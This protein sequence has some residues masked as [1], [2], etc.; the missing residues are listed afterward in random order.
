MKTRM[1]LWTGA[2]VLVLAVV[3]SVAFMNRGHAT[4][5]AMG[6]ADT[7]PPPA[8]SEK[9]IEAA[10]PTA[11]TPDG[12]APYAN[13]HYHFALAYPKNLAVT[14]HTENGG[15]MTITFED[16]AGEQ[17]FQIF[18]LPYSGTQ[19]DAA[20]FKLDEPSGVMDSPTDVLVDGARATM[21]FGRNSIMGD[22]REVWCIHGGF[23]YEVTT[24]KDLDPWLA[25]IMSTWK[26]AK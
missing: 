9:V 3:A 22:T 7:V 15:A 12:F 8:V 1:W 2:A 24:Y 25:Q 5:V 23:L 26:W 16:A 20:R 18:V 19:I 13:A 10:A 21:F 6:D 17:S 14:E 11:Q 4:T